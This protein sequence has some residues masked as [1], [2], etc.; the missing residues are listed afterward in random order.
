VQ[1]L[2]KAI[3]RAL[4]ILIVA[5]AV[6]YACEDL[7]LRYRVNRH[8]DA[9]VFDQVLIYPEGEVKGGKLEYYMDQAQPQTCVHAMFPHFGDTPCWY[10]SRHTMRR[11]AAVPRLR[12]RGIASV[13]WTN[14]TSRI[15]RC[16][17]RREILGK[18]PSHGSTH[19][20]VNWVATDVHR[21]QGRPRGRFCHG[22]RK[23]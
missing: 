18:A 7:L 3:G 13:S 20:P 12:S 15:V 16:C 6:V 4:L 9:A 17:A 19:L 5:V 23:A 8:P 22:D 10:L 1:R 2:L 14:I 21:R 11:I